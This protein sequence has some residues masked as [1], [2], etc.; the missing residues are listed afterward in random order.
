MAGVTRPPKS[1]AVNIIQLVTANTNRFCLSVI[2]APM[3][4]PASGGLM[5]TG[6]REAG[7]IVIK[8]SASPP[9]GLM[10]LLAIPPL[11]SF[12]DI[13]VFMA[14]HANDRSITI[15]YIVLMT[16]LTSQRLVLPQQRKF[17][18]LMRKSMGI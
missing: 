8:F 6:Q 18:K 10:A 3:A 9:H 1:V 4:L 15:S 7:F 12:M 11:S 13:V 5:G 2:T 16:M 17:G 14:L